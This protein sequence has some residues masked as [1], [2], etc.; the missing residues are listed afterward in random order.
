MGKLQRFRRWLWGYG[1]GKYDPER[2]VRALPTER[3]GWLRAAVWRQDGFH[4]GGRDLIWP[5]DRIPRK[6]WLAFR[7]HWSA[8]R[9]TWIKAIIAAAVGAMAGMLHHCSI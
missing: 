7:E 4:A 9:E 2:R 3:T 6:I 8:Y 1:V 5:K